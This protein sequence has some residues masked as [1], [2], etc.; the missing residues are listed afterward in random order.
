MYMSNADRYACSP[1]AW[2]YTPFKHVK[3]ALGAGAF[4]RA[5]NLARPAAPEAGL[6]ISDDPSC[7]PP[8]AEKELKAGGGSYA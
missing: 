4:S 7:S 6:D 5:N 2:I 3:K 1:N 8:N